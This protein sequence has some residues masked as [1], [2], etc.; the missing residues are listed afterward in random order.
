MY[1]AGRLRTASRPSRIWICSARY[2]F[3]TTVPTA[4]GWDGEDSSGLIAMQYSFSLLYIVGSRRLSIRV[5][6]PNYIKL[7]GKALT[8]FPA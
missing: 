3:F 7:A 6:F 8:D 2:S 1:I 5:T 4:S